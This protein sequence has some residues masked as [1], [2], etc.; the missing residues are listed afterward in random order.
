[1]KLVIS[2]VATS[3]ELKDEIVTSPSGRRMLGYIVPI[4][5]FDRFALHIFQALG[6]EIDDAWQLVQEVRKQAF[7]QTATWGLRYWEQRFGLPVNESIPIEQRRSRILVW[8]NT[9]WPMTRRRM[10]TI[11]SEAVGLPVEIEEN[12]APYTFLVLINWNEDKPLNL[13]RVRE[14]IEEAKPAHLAFRFG[15]VNPVTVEIQEESSTYH[16]KLQMCGTFL[17]GQRPGGVY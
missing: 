7:V 10:K 12:V 5:D 9:E 4:Y 1:M 13:A 2:P 17:A 3:D 16:T 6:L 11:V 8:M 15:A 14:V